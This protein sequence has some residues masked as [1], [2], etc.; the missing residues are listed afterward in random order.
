MSLAPRSLFVNAGIAFTQSSRW[1]C[2]HSSLTLRSLKVHAAFTQSSC[3]HCVHSS[4]TLALRSV[5]S[6]R[7][8][9][10]A[11]PPRFP[12]R[13]C[14]GRAVVVLEGLTTQTASVLQRGG[15]GGDEEQEQQSAGAVARR[16]AEER[17]VEE[18]GAA[19]CAPR[20]RNFLRGGAL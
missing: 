3:W 5:G 2:V 18:R 11:A 12:L 9:V 19:V 10:V 6:E 8:A 7:Q 17:G 13:Y 14:T 15:D 16:G 4:L 20:W 1:H